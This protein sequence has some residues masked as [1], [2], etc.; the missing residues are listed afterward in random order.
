MYQYIT[1]N[2]P[3][4][5][6][7]YYFFRNTPPVQRWRPIQLCG[8]R[9]H[10]IPRQLEEFCNDKF[11]DGY[12]G[13][14]FDTNTTDIAN[15]SGSHPH[16]TAT[17]KTALEKCE[18]DNVKEFADNL[19][20]FIKDFGGNEKLNDLDFSDIQSLIPS[21]SSQQGKVTSSHGRDYKPVKRFDPSRPPK[22]KASSYIVAGHNLRPRKK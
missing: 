18:D 16:Y 21:G 5:N 8:Q 17:V 6:R 11:T 14:G 22:S 12:N 7:G 9:H 19:A 15:H 3:L 1:K 4:H 13:L 2:S 10:V 20:A